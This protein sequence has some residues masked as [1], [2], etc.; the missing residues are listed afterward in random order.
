MEGSL[1]LGWRIPGVVQRDEG[2]DEGFPRAARVTAEQGGKGVAPTRLGLPADLDGTE[3]GPAGEEVR[4]QR[5]QGITVALLGHEIASPGVLAKRQLESK[6]DQ[7][8]NV[9][10]GI[11]LHQQAAMDQGPC[12]VGG[13]SRI[14][15]PDHDE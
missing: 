15:D 6:R 3:T 1:A 13:L 5:A 11:G 4:I 14:E 2:Q 7:S 10:V 9:G 12:L 8:I